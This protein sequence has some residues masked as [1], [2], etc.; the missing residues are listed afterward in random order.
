LAK[1]K[2]NLPLFLVKDQIFAS[3]E[4]NLTLRDTTDTHSPLKV[5]S[6][7]QKTKLYF[8]VGKI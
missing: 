8:Y 3:S 2:E 4:K 1:F 6:Q 5:E 7:F